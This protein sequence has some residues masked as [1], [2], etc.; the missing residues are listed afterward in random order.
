MKKNSMVFAAIAIFAF[1]SN[2][3]AAAEQE[4]K[5]AITEQPKSMKRSATK[6]SLL[7]MGIN[8][9]S[10]APKKIANLPRPDGVTSSTNVSSQSDVTLP[11]NVVSQPDVVTSPRTTGV[12]SPGLEREAKK[13]ESEI[14]SLI[15][16]PGK[17]TE[18]L[19]AD[20]KV[21]Y[22][23]ACSGVT[24]AIIDGMKTVTIGLKK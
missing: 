1:G 9:S 17:R 11:K 7:S 8:T 16:A 20:K 13:T 19:L 18:V 21:Y 14:N 22:K 5:T 24:L 4:N 2:L 6:S 23:T 3:S 15:G 10:S 12:S